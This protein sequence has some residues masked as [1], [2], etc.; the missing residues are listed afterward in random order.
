MDTLDED[1]LSVTISSPD[2]LHSLVARI[3]PE[4]VSRGK[5]ALKLRIVGIDVVSV[6]LA[7]FLPH[8]LGAVAKMDLALWLTDIHKTGKTLSDQE[9][10]FWSGNSAAAR[11]LRRRLSGK[12]WRF[13]TPE[14]YRQK[15]LKKGGDLGLFLCAPRLLYSSNRPKTDMS[16]FRT[17]FSRTVRREDI[18]VG[19]SGWAY[20]VI[21]GD[22]QAGGLSTP[23]IRYLIP[24]T[25]YAAG[26]SKG[27]YYTE[28]TEEGG[29]EYCGTFFYYEPESTT[30][31]SYSTRE[32]FFNKSQCAAVFEGK[33]PADTSQH[34]RRIAN[35]LS[36]KWPADMMMTP[37]EAYQERLQYLK[38]N[39]WR[40]RGDLAPPAGDQVSGI[41]FIDALWKTKVDPHWQ[42][43]LPYADDLPQTKRYAGY[44]AA[45][46]ALE[47]NY[48]Q[49]ICLGGKQ[50]NLDV[51]VL[52]HMIGM[53]Q[54]VTE[55]LDTRSREECFA[56][57]VYLE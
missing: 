7:G 47:D 56:S 48:D 6:M 38:V 34:I 25:R 2:D 32:D 27:L 21:D 41:S 54:V 17:V 14:G 5:V 29:E 8:R 18:E 13:R 55:V 22:A 46:Y 40:T 31:L 1:V 24:V 45:M 33:D 16:L 36:G 12:E 19:F 15:A 3:T 10:N 4:A 35:H 52:T 23:D 28:D 20:T 42:D 44:A 43:K 26:M 49:E 9:L 57:L 53:Y 11:N 50:R 30:F 51:I 37:L 39:E